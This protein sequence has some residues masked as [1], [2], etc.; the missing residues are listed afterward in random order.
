LITP[1]CTP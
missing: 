1:D